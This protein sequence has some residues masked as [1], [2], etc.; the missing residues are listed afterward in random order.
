MQC[1]Q[2]RATPINPNVIYMI[3]QHSQLR[4]A[5]MIENWR[6]STTT[7]SH[8]IAMSTKQQ[9]IT[10]GIL[11]WTLHFALRTNAKIWYEAKGERQERRGC[12]ANTQFREVNSWYLSSVQLGSPQRHPNIFIEISQWP[13]L[14]LNIKLRL[15]SKKKGQ[16][17]KPPIHTSWKGVRHGQFKVKIQ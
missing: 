11:G 15:Q 13:Y 7:G 6:E 16:D 8:L 1:K 5:W 9:A 10:P 14:R 12:P 3:H 4:D 17:Q 2:V